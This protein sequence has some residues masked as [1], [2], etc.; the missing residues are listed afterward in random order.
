MSSVIYEPVQLTDNLLCKYFLHSDKI[1]VGSIPHFH[2]SYELT[3]VMD[4]YCSIEQNGVSMMAGPGEILFTNSDVIHS[5]SSM[6]APCQRITLLIPREILYRYCPD[7]ERA[8]FSIPKNSSAYNRIF[9]DA[10]EIYYLL[11]AKN[12]GYVLKVNSLVLDILSLLVN[13][14]QL[15]YDNWLLSYKGGTRFIEYISINYKDDITLQSAAEYFGFNK[16]YFS[17]LF[18]EETG[19]SFYN[20]L[21]SV[22]FGHA[23]FMLCTTDLSVC[24]VAESSGFKNER[25]F[26]EMYKKYFKTTPDKYRKEH[27][28]HDE[29][30]KIHDMSSSVEN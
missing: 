10:V 24:D 3:C 4:G 23:L 21:T 2:S 13:E 9:N 25:S 26:I 8:A 15:D 6:K 22:R 19:T 27:Q 7:I 18:H 28:N 5:P 29:L 14:C 1:S 16:T 20:C 30:D 11:L 12:I 17:H